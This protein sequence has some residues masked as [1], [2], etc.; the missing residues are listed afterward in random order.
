M[1]EKIFFQS[2]LPRSQSSLVQNLLAQNVDMYSTPTCGVIEMLLN[3]RNIHSNAMETKAQDKQVMDNALR[4]YCRGALEGYFNAITDKKYVISK[5]RGWSVTYDFLNWFYPEPKIIVLI[6]DLRAI[7][8]SLEKAFR[9]HPEIDS[10]IQN[11]NEL[12]GTTVDKRISVF[13]QSPPLGPALDILYDVIARGLAPKMLFVKSENLCSQPE[14]EMKKIYGYLGIPEYKHDFNNV[15]QITQE[16]DIFSLPLG[17]HKIRKEVRPVKNDYIEVLGR[18]NCDAIKE[19]YD[20]F[21]RAFSY[22]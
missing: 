16:N 8:S 5:S 18:A 17:N 21:Y 19:R 15:E 7:F 13:A 22:Q 11:W 3:S 9:N 14:I 6:R 20:W 2:S 12:Q 1:V 4:G 10:G